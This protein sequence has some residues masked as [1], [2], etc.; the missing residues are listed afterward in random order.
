MVNIL[1]K[2]IAH[3]A[4]REVAFLYDFMFV[5]VGREALVLHFCYEV[6]SLCFKPFPDVGLF[7]V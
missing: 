3:S 2:S 1:A 6:F 4:F 7:N 5:V